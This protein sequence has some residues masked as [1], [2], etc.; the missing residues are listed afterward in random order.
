MRGA[1]VWG[2][3]W[4]GELGCAHC[5]HF[6]LR[7]G[8]YW[9]RTGP[10]CGG[11]GGS[12]VSRAGTRFESHLGHVFSLF[13]GLWASECAQSVH[14]WAPSGAFFVAG[15][16]AVAEGLLSSLR[17]GVCPLVPVHGPRW[18]GQHD[19]NNPGS[20]SFVLDAGCS[21]ASSSAFWCLFCVFMVGPGA[22][23]MTCGPPVGNRCRRTPTRCLTRVTVADSEPT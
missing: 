5:A 6:G 10:D 15:P 23:E 16:V 1:P 20:N 13:R 11:F 4:V 14:C 12:G 21:P 18:L 17:A 22:G 2:R 8:S 9:C 19:L 3:P 7:T